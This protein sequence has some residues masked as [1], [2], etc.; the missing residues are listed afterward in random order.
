MIRLV[1]AAGYHKDIGIEYEGERL[2]EAEGIRATLALLTRIREEIVQ[3]KPR[4]G[5]EPATRPAGS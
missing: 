2:S 5:G 1:L 4:G 3:E